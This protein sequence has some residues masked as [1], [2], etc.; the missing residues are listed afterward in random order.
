[1]ANSWDHYVYL[2][3]RSAREKEFL[4]FMTMACEKE[5]GFQCPACQKFKR[6]PQTFYGHLLTKHMGHMQVRRNSQS[7]V[8]KEIYELGTLL[9]NMLSEQEA[10]TFPE[11]VSKIAQIRAGRM[12]NCCMPFCDEH[13]SSKQEMVTHIGHYHAKLSDIFAKAEPYPD[14]DGA[15]VRYL[16]E[17]G[18]PRPQEGDDSSSGVDED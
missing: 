8:F 12:Y 4:D 7:H 11:F 18:Q 10:L 2:A 6:Y 17:R 13:T 9:D 15:Y 5:E 3:A 14:P 16:R 1:M